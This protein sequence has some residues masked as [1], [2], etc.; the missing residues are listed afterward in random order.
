MPR[1]AERRVPAPLHW[2]PHGGRGAGRRRRHAGHGVTRA[3]PDERR[4]TARAVGRDVG[5]PQ[6]RRRR[7]R[8]LGRPP[9][10]WVQRRRQPSRRGDLP[11]RRRLGQSGVRHADHADLGV[12]RCVGI[13]AVHGDERAAARRARPVVARRRGE[14]ARAGLGRN[15]TG[16]DPAPPEPHRWAPRCV[17]AHRDGCAWRSRSRHGRLARLA[18]DAPATAQLPAGHGE[19]GTATPATS[20]SPTSSSASAASRCEPSPRPTSSSRWA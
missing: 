4:T 8:A 18:A 15:S 9:C 17:P 13:Q 7:A 5:S 12:P 1:D 16:H 19:P 14:S 11:S 6:P 3:C 20:C 10:T 2:P